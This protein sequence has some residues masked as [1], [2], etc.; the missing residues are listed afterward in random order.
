MRRADHRYEQSSDHNSRRSAEQTNE[1]L[2]RHQRLF[3]HRKRPA[4]LHPTDT[5]VVVGKQV[6]AGKMPRKTAA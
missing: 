4:I 5:G 1:V 3:A 2:F 6:Y